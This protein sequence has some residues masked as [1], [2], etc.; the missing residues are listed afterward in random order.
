MPP[1]DAPAFRAQRGRI[2]SQSS[3]LGGFTQETGSPG[4]LR[5]EAKVFFGL[6]EER[7]QKII[8]FDQ[9]LNEGDTPQQNHLRIV[10]DRFVHWFDKLEPMDR[11]RIQNAPE[12]IDR[13]AVIRELR[14]RDWMASQPKVRREQFAR[15]SGEAKKDFIKKLRAEERERRQEWQMAKRFWK[16][17]EKGTLLHSRLSDFPTEVVVF[18]N[19]Y[20]KPTLSKAE[21][22]RLDQAE[23]KWPLY[24]LTLVE[25]ADKHPP[26]LPGP[27]G[28]KSFAELPTDVKNKLKNKKGI[29]PPKLAN[30]ENH[31]PEFAIAVSNF[32]SGKN[33]FILP[34]EL[35]P[36]GYACL[37][38]PMK[39]FLDKKLNLNDDD[40][41]F[42]KI[43]EGKWP[44]YPLA[45]QEIARKYNLQPPWH[46]LPGSRERWDNYRLN[47]MDN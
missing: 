2:G 21:E 17:L 42:L 47:R 40:K 3:C 25:L 37:S 35:W 8:N 28:P 12:P 45:I 39:E 19:E 1:G 26:A 27:N 6:P 15:L 11:Q 33:N 43:A 46:A 10:M 7:R 16:E 5:E 41:K 36:W 13:L 31:W 22:D 34:N 44:E 24:P 29:F 38:A 23:G 30:A 4:S 9:K 18:V 32:T 14:D 20:L